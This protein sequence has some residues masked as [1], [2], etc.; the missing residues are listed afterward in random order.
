M[1]KDEVIPILKTCPFCGDMPQIVSSGTFRVE[2]AD[3][4]ASGPPSPTLRGA[5]MRWNRR[6]SGPVDDFG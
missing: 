1:D 3:C 5:A 4:G 2:C 6:G